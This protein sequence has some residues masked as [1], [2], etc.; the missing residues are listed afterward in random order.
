MPEECTESR[1]LTPSRF[2]VDCWCETVNH[3]L[4]CRLINKKHIFAPKW[5][6][7][8]EKCFQTSYYYSSEEWVLRFYAA[9]PKIHVNISFLWITGANSVSFAFKKINIKLKSDQ[10][11]TGVVLIESQKKITFKKKNKYF[12]FSRTNWPVWPY[13]WKEKIKN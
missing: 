10:I 5:L 2:V 12:E 4:I 8:S 1:I 9:F 3:F 7:I 13:I 6:C 11:S